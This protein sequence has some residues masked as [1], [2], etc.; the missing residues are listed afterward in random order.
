MKTRITQI[1]QSLVIRI[2]ER[3][4]AQAGIREDVTVE[5]QGNALIIRSATKPRKG[6]A[7]SFRRMAENGD[8]RMVDNCG[9]LQSDW[10]DEEWQWE[11]S[12]V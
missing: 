10:D 12:E 8:D 11:E 1:G 6:W 5:K 2:P 4:L 3:L 7:E 9:Y